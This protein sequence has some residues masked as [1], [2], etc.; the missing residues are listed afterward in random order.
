[1]EKAI[2]QVASAG[3]CKLDLNWVVII[4]VTIEQVSPKSHLVIKGWQGAH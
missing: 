2:S 1:M 4:K 3:P